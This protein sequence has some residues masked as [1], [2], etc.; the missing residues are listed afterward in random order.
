[1][2]ARARLVLRE[3]LRLSPKAR[4]DIAGTLLHSLDEP[5]DG[6]VEAAWAAE[7]GRRLRDVESGKVKLIP[8]GKA[9]KSLW[10]G[11][12]RARARAAR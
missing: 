7:I 6:H 3:A 9:R 10:A 1:M 2:T 8:W 12:K 11:L 5:D 4:A